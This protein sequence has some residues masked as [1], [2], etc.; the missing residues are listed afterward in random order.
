MAQYAIRTRSGNLIIDESWSCIAD[1]IS[2]FTA[3]EIKRG[4]DAGT[5]VMRETA[6]D[7]WEEVDHG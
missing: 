3:F 6:E 2:G 1:V 4:A 7:E 5:L